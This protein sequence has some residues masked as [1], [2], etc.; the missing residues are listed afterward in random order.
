MTCHAASCHVRSGPVSSRMCFVGLLTRVI[1]GK[2]KK[3]PKNVVICET[4]WWIK[5]KNFV[6]SFAQVWTERVLCDGRKWK[7]PKLIHKIEKFSNNGVRNSRRDY[8]R[9]M[10]RQPPIPKYVCFALFYG[11][12]Q[13]R[14]LYLFGENL[15]ISTRKIEFYLN[16]SGK[17]IERH[18]SRRFN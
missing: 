11:F 10:D 1:I 7:R 4:D 17:G 18:T 15:D 8:R 16:R 5:L 14:I 2:E 6:P 3:L 13:R 9:L 12:Q